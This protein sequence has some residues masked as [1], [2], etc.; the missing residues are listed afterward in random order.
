MAIDIADIKR[1]FCALEKEAL[2]TLGTSCEAFP[3]W[4]VRNETPIY[5]TNRTGRVSPM[6]DYGEE[7]GS[8][9]YRIHARLVW[10]FAD[11]DYAGE[12]DEA[13]DISIPIIINYFDERELLQS[14]AYP[15]APLDIRWCRLE[16]CTGYSAFPTSTP[17][18]MEV[19]AEFVWRVEFD[20]TETQVYN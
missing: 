8:H 13:V 2:A 20:Q 5:W 9:A 6:E 7:L 10:A 19:G 18:L 14:V 15:S 3:R 17:G 16:D 11:A 4:F 12:V 1:R